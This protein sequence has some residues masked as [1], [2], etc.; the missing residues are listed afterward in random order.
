M[1]VYACMGTPDAAPGAGTMGYQAPEVLQGIGV[2][3][4]GIDVVRNSFIVRVYYYYSVF[5]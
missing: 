1:C 3:A 4:M 2:G 5:L